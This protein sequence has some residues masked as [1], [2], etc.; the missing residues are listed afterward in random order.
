M[1]HISRLASLVALGVFVPT[2][3][4]AQ[5]DYFADMGATKQP[6]ENFKL[7]A[8]TTVKLDFRNASVDAVLKVFSDASGVAILKDPALVGGLSIQSPKPQNLKDAFAMLNSALGLRNFEIKKDGNFLVVK[9]KPQANRG[10][11][12]RGG[13][14]GFSG[15]GG[16][17]GGDSGAAA[18]GMGGFDLSK[19]GGSTSQIKTYQLKFS[20][21]TQVARIV[22][23]V[24]QNSGQDP[25]GGIMSM[26]GGMG[27]TPSPGTSVTIPGGAAV[28]APGRGPSAEPDPVIA[29]P[30]PQ[31]GGFGGGGGFNP[32]QF[33]RGGA[34]TT[35]FGGMGGLEVSDVVVVTPL[36]VHPRM[37]TPTQ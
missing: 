9:A 15:F 20:N 26:L 23:E 21:A 35:G 4:N 14:G 6:W 32:F 17:P 8:K 16:A 37:T 33:G 10:G 34:G 13:F 30:D 36:S 31:R 19:L 25:L 18:G 11:N 24:F 27:G 28:V 3:A 5:V 12:T 2:I 29:A 22:N 7:N 1:K